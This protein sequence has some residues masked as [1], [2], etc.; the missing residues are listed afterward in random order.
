MIF[1]LPLTNF[2]GEHVNLY[3]DLATSLTL[4]SGVAITWRHGWVFY[5]ALLLGTV[6]LA[7]R[8]SC[9]IHPQL[10]PLR[11]LLMLANILVF[12]AVLLREVFAKGRVTSMRIQG[13]IAVYLLLG[14][15]WAHAYTLVN[16]HNAHA[17]IVQTGTPNTVS[18]WLY[19]SFITL[20][21]VGYGDIVPT[22]R[23]ARVL[24]MGEALTG[25]LYLAVMLARLVALQVS[26]GMTTTPSE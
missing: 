23:V 7:V 20:T 1:V 6:S 22:T 14:I 12:C 24:C 13:A 8:W 2:V 10:L 18:E 19:Y 5:L 26:E 25:Q 16:A 3:S 4:I 15:A 9:W 21:T 17:F 11:E